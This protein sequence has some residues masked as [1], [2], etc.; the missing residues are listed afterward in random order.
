MGT[1]NASVRACPF[2]QDILP[3]GG[4]END[5]AVS[6]IDSLQSLAR[7]ASRLLSQRLT[8]GLGGKRKFTERLDYGRSECNPS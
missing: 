7:S 6:A 3:T 5:R 1:F 2:G 8:A 4:L